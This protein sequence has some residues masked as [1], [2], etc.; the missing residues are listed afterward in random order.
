MSNSSNTTDPLTG[1]FETP[2]LDKIIGYTILFNFIPC[3]IG[4]AIS[5]YAYYLLHHVEVTN[6]RKSRMSDGD[7]L[8]ANILPYLLVLNAMFCQNFVS[9]FEKR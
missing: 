3:I 1:I 6:K 8:L 4:T 5:M 9:G 7:K 2:T